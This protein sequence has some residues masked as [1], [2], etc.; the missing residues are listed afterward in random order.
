MTSRNGHVNRL[1]L[2]KKKRRKK[3]RKP[4]IRHPTGE[5]R[6]PAF[7]RRHAWW[8]FLLIILAYGFWYVFR[9]PWQRRVDIPY[10]HHL[11]EN[12]K[13]D[14]DGDKTPPESN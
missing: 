11:Y 8:I 7:F 6:I 2:L 1:K 3:R 9:G 13:E 10:R 12:L 14:R 5:N 4:H